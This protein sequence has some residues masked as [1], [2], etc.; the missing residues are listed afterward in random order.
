MVVTEVTC[1]NQTVLPNFIK[2]RSKTFTISPKSSDIGIYTLTV[3][4]RDTSIFKLHT[5]YTFI[6][7]VNKEIT[8]T[9]PIKE[10]PKNVTN[11]TVEEEEEVI[12]N[13]T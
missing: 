2:Y 3:T 8:Y 10:P 12:G 11:T 6:I 1:N 4:I 13:K 7:V 9:P 5:L